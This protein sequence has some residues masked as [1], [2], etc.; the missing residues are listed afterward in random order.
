MEKIGINKKILG[1]KI[2]LKNFS[3]KIV[4]K[5]EYWVNS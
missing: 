1:Q 3:W 4:K 5:L 2:D